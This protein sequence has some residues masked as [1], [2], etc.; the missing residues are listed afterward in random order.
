[1]EVE[2]GRI[3]LVGKIRDVTRETSGA[4]NRGRVRVEGVPFECETERKEVTALTHLVL[5]FQNENL[6]VRQVGE[7]SPCTS[8]QSDMYVYVCKD[9]TQVG[10]V[11]SFMGWFLQ[12]WVRLRTF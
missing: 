10:E 1:M 7:V 2:P 3:L 12:L 6:V 9:I 8:G 4:F 11:S 5:D